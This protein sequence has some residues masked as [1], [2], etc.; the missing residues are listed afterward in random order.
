MHRANHSHPSRSARRASLRTSGAR[1]FSLLDVLVSLAVILVLLGIMLP[2]LTH[3]RG[4]AQRVVCG[5]NMHQIYLGIVMFAGDEEDR[6]PE[7]QFLR[8]IGNRMPAPQEM[9][10][11]HAHRNAGHLRTQW[12]GIGKLYDGGYLPSRGVF[13]CPSHTGE[14]P[15][16][17]YAEVWSDPSLGSIAGNYH[18]RGV[19]VNNST[20]LPDIFPDSSA[21]LADAMRTRADWNHETGTNVTRVDGSVFWYQ[22]GEN[23]ISERLPDD[24][25]MPRA[26]ELIG[27]IWEMLDRGPK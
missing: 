20:I 8:R 3:V 2:S 21:L 22:D 16:S 12:D 4:I 14:H 26:A 6:L 24:G 1:G 11:L 19:G 18:Y 9:I 7:S 5:S 15:K 23:E 27:G 10:T 17:R 25:N 13:Y